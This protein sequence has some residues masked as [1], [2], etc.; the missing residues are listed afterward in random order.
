MRARACVPVRASTSDHSISVSVCVPHGVCMM[1]DVYMLMHVCDMCT[2]SP[3][4]CACCACTQPTLDQYQC[5]YHMVYVWCVMCTCCAWCT[6]CYVHVVHVVH[7]LESAFSTLVVSKS[8]CCDHSGHEFE[9]ICRNLGYRR[10]PRTLTA[11]GRLQI[12]DIGIHILGT[13]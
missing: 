4:H 3:Q 12:L 1:C 10:D 9:P 5:V 8:A 7:T 13:T 11:H 6:V 2:C